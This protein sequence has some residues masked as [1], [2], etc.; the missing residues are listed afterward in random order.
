MAT[1]LLFYDPFFWFCDQIQNIS[2]SKIF[3]SGANKPQQR[4]AERVFESRRAATE[5]G[6]GY[7]LGVQPTVGLGAALLIFLGVGVFAAGIAQAFQMV[8]F[9]AF[10]IRVNG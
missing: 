2:N 4:C 1:Q 6:K 7:S 10:R 5:N 3:F 9:I 8:R